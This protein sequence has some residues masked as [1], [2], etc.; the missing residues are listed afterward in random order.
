M[1]FRV[2]TLQMA[3]MLKIT[4]NLSQPDI[5]NFIRKQRTNSV[6]RAL[7]SSTEEQPKKKPTME[8]NTEVKEVYSTEDKLS[9]LS[10]HQK[11]LYDS[12]NI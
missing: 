8:V 7:S 6:K 5:V 12:L 2:A 3:S 10:P 1:K 11:L 9:H 4:T